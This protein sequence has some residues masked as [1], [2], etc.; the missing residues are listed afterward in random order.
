MNLKYNIQVQIYMD[1]ESKAD[2]DYQARKFG[3]SK[4]AYIRYLIHQPQWSRDIHKK[5]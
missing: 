2:L 4:S 3:M 5:G 1:E